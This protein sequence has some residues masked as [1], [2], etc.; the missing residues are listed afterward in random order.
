MLI[1]SDQNL[2]T[3]AS[4]TILYKIHNT[5]PALWCLP[6]RNGHTKMQTGLHP[7]PSIQYYRIVVIQPTSDRS[8]PFRYDRARIGKWGESMKT[9]QIRY[10]WE[11]ALLYTREK[12]KWGAILADKL[13][14]GQIFDEH[15]SL[16]AHTLDLLHTW[17]YQLK[18]PKLGQ[19]GWLFEEDIPTKLSPRIPL[20]QIAGVPCSYT[21]YLYNHADEHPAL[22]V[23][24]TRGTGTLEVR[25]T[26]RNHIYGDWQLH[27]L[28]GID[29]GFSISD[30][31]KIS[32]NQ[33]HWT[34]RTPFTSKPTGMALDTGDDMHLRWEHRLTF[35]KEPLAMEKP[36]AIAEWYYNELDCETFPGEQIKPKAVYHPVD[37]RG[38]LYTMLDVHNDQDVQQWAKRLNKISWLT[39]LGH[40]TITLKEPG[41]VELDRARI[42]WL[43]EDLLVQL[44]QARSSI[45]PW[46]HK[47]GHDVITAKDVVT[48]LHQCITGVL[49][50]IHITQLQ[51]W[52][53]ASRITVETKRRPEWAHPSPVFIM[54]IG[55]GLS[56]HANPI[57]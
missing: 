23:I 34:I 21:S 35:E 6:L 41:D 37:V 15:T 50:R 30:V 52:S 36:Y 12:R 7:G 54:G 11:F 24:T 29:L 31:V 48:R 4:H 3:V 57:G 47:A 42:R 18:E 16:P 49:H 10:D 27:T 20:V 14:W 17:T 13:D 53:D 9:Y 8:N 28:S 33:L 55:W 45:P 44:Y 19:I 32:A 25:P 2:Y 22:P 40:G 38:P 39:Y 46:T 43:W 5:T 56:R 26:T 51:A 1:C